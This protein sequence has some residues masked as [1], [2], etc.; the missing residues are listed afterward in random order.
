MS[1]SSREIDACTASNCVCASASTSA[2]NPSSR[3]PSLRITVGRVRP[4]SSRVATVTKNARNTIVSRPGTVSGI[5]NAAASVTT[6]RIPDQEIT[7]GHRHEGAGSRRPMDGM[8]QR[9]M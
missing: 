8:S 2:W 4:C 3:I 1:S 9:G 7:A 6:P 5:A